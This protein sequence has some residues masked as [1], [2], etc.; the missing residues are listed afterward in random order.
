MT[1]KRGRKSQS[2]LSVISRNGIEAIARPEAPDNL[3]EEQAAE[4]KAIVNR[5]PAD[6]FTRESH[7]LLAQYCRHAVTALRVSQL[8]NQEEQSD[9]FNVN[10]YDQLLRMQARESNILACLAT[11]L[12]LS[13]QAKYT[14]KAA[15]TASNNTGAGPKPW[16]R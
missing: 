3:T 10:D 4:W 15:G 9:E 16:E 5:M 11:K 12:R 2:S 13:Q 6:W 1:K 14:T 7:P 8:I